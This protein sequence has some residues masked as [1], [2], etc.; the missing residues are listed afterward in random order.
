MSTRSKR[1]VAS[2]RA[3]SRKSSTSRT[4]TCTQGSGAGESGTY[5]VA[6]LARSNHCSPCPCP[7]VCDGRVQPMSQQTPKKLRDSVTRSRGL[8]RRIHGRVE[9]TKLSTNKQHSLS[10]SASRS[11]A[12][13]CNALLRYTRYQ[14]LKGWTRLFCFLHAEGEKYPP[15][16]PACHSQSK[17]V[18]LK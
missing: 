14:G 16:N 18:V 9:D 5:A 8:G 10:L 12:H 11:M 2:G 13:T 17:L 1:D 4:R 6:A 3:R 7:A 15:Q